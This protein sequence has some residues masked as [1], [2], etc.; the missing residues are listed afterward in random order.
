MSIASA[1]ADG[2]LAY[3]VK[4]VLDGIFIEKNAHLLTVL[5]FVIVA[6]YLIK[7]FLR[8]ALNY[9]LRYMGQKVVQVLRNELYAKIIYL[10]IR[11]FTNNATGTLTSRVIAD[12]NM[13]QNSVAT[14]VV[15]IRDLL[16]VVGLIGVIFY[17]NAKMAILAIIVYPIFF[18]PII[19]L[20]KRIRRYSKRVQEQMSILTSDL[21]ES[22]SGIRVVKAFAQEQKEIEKFKKDNSIIVKLFLK[23]AVAAE[24]TSPMMEFVSSIG[25]AAIVYLGGSQVIGSQITAGDFFAFLTAVTMVYEPVKRL[26]NS[27]A[28]VQQA[29]AAAERVFEMLETR[30]E[31]L[32]N[33]G[34]LVC[35]AINKDIRFKNVGF[36]YEDPDKPVIQNLT[37]DVSAGS[38]IAFVGHSGAGKS[39]IANLIPRFYDVT[40]GEIT[41]DGINIKDFKVHSLRQNIGYVSQEPFLFD[42]TILNNIAYTTDAKSEEDII[43]AA[44]A[45]Y[46]HDFIMELPEQYNTMV[47]ERGVKLSGGQKQ[48]ITIARALL[49]NPPILILDEATSALDTESEREVQK[50]L[51]NLM[52]GRTS[53]VIAH[54]LTTIIN[55]DKIIVLESG[56][57]KA[58]G[59]HEE[60]LASSDVYKKL[61]HMQLQSKNEG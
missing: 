48:R 33:D 20:S 37:F 44:K 17:L 7:S 24:V 61:Y 32:D 1:G 23:A 19:I 27:N 51:D 4:P 28:T 30:N 38:T 53:F 13:I 22:F 10:P 11:F 31:I 56:E 54:R 16:S 50:A 26:G 45:A 15:V 47:G 14:T 57:I 12:V 18:H 35:S 8:F 39:T 25:I 36:Y 3:V 34:S 52:I 55:A 21:Q 5:P 6:L 49:K 58:S 43:N 59:K 42:D 60:L 40:E 41:I 29:L 46:A 9:T 2:A